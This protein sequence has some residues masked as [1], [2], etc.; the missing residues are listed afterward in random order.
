MDSRHYSSFTDVLRG[1]INLEE[2]LFSVFENGPMLIQDSPLNDEVATSK[3]KQ[4][5][6]VNFSAKEDKLLV[7][8]WLNT[9]VEIGR[10]SCRER[11]SSPV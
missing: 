2:E 10:A 11:V 9:S 7:A 4:A 5:R 8:A 1:N 6:G 3:K